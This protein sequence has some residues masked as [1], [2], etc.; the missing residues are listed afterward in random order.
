MNPTDFFLR[1]YAYTGTWDDYLLAAVLIVG[2]I[3]GVMLFRERP[4]HAPMVHSPPL[5]WLRAGLYFCFVF[6]FATLTGVVKAIAQAP[7]VTDAQATDPIW[8]LALA[9]CCGIVI[10]AYVYWWPRGTLTHG[11]RLYLAPT[12]IYGLLW[13]TA[14]GLMM[15]SVYALL[16][17][18]GLPAL[19]NAVLLIALLSVYNMNY[20]LGWWD[21]HVSPP[22]NIRATNTGKVL[23]AHQPFL[24]SS[25][26]FF[27]VYG[28][29]GIFVLLTAA[30]MCASAI[31][32]R[33]P[34]FWAPDG[35]PV[36]LDTAIGE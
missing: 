15:L 26:A 18:F 23:L 16:E 30:A 24:F 34:P 4:K 33:M 28:N 13:G 32:L 14:S 19:A 7:L 27:I 2:A 29:A 11:R 6:V 35:G 8:N 5:A 36:S 3:L 12:T 17:R 1:G 20:Q 31:A 9:G 25:L 10:W 21:L 22:H